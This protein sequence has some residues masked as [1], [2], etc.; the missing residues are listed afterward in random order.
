MYVFFMHNC[1]EPL[2]KRMLYNELAIV[3]KEIFSLQSVMYVLP[4]LDNYVLV[5]PG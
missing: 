3:D 2:T 1:G 5:I 4:P